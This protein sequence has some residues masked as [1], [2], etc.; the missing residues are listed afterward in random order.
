MYKVCGLCC[1]W[2][3]NRGPKSYFLNKP[4]EPLLEQ[5]VP[6]VYMKMNGIPTCHCEGSY[7]L[8]GADPYFYCFS[9]K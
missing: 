5:D 1:L 4:E 8:L 9:G 6:Y 3:L 7:P 2:S